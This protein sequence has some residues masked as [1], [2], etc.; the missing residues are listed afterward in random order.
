MKRQDLVR[1]KREVLE[2]PAPA[3]WWL[4]T[5]PGGFMAGIVESITKEP[6]ALDEDVY[7]FFLR[8]VE[9]GALKPVWI[10]DSVLDE[11]RIKVGDWLCLKSLG[12]RPWRGGAS[13]EA[14]SLERI[15]AKDIPAPG[16]REPAAAG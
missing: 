9:T 12:M 8:D 10:M 1:R 4:P 16:K 11:D 3:D 7:I 14:F 15:R 13:C 6:D 5:E 2:R